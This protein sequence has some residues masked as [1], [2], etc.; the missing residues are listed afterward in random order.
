MQTPIRLLLSLFFASAVAGTSRAARAQSAPS[1]T[2]IGGSVQRCEP[3]VG[4]ACVS[5]DS[6]GKTPQPAGVPENAINLAD[7]DANLFYQLQLSIQNPSSNYTL[8]VW[9]GTQ[10][11]SV[12]A[13]RQSSATSACWPVAPFQIVLTSSFL[14]NARVQDIASGVFAT[15]HPVTYTPA[16]DPIVC[17]SP[18]T[19]AKNLTLYIFFVDAGSNPVGTVQQ[20]PITYDTRAAAVSGAISVS[21]GGADVVVTIPP[22][23][24]PDTQSYNVYCDPGQDVTVSAG[25]G[26]ATSSE[27]C[28][29][30]V[31]GAT[32][33]GSAQDAG[34][35]GLAKYL[36]ATGSTTA[37]SITVGS[38]ENGHPYAVAVAAVDAVGNVGPL[39]NVACGEP[40]AGATTGGASC[41]AGA[42]GAGA[43]A[44]AGGFGVL[45]ISA[46][47]AVLRKRKRAR[48]S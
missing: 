16:T 29:D 45:L 24:D 47:G 14:L 26:G 2:G 23:T 25:D 44:G 22:T 20:F 6:P 21:A 15:T 30:A 5:A 7:C 33:S 48:S 43:P 27:T 12:L 17:Q 10:D 37:K 38:L 11:C 39:S 42:V 13:N 31:L 46:L 34:T 1:V 3:P 9:A 40:E 41:S 28:A 35:S 19:A 32:S 36:C 8:A 18:Q 4:S